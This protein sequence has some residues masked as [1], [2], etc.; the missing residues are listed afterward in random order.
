MRHAV[1]A[2]SL[3]AS[4]CAGYLRPPAAPPRSWD[5]LPVGLAISSELDRCQIDTV[6][7]A[8][9]L[10][11]SRVGRGRL[12]EVRVVGPDHLAVNGLPGW[13]TVGVS[14]GPLGDPET[15]DEAHIHIDP[16]DG[17]IHSVD[18]R[19]GPCSL[20]AYAHEL[21]HALGLDHASLEGNLMG[22]E[23]D[24]GAMELTDAQVEAV[25]VGTVTRLALKPPPA[26]KSLRWTTSSASTRR[27]ESGAP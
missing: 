15:L 9:A 2:A 10:L 20:R 11:E 17:R 7:A 23:H 16:S 3:L 26:G 14:A 5:E 1:L 24:P 12:F 25:L 22:R 27:R 21:G 19:L 4:G 18:V 6:L 8:V 13:H